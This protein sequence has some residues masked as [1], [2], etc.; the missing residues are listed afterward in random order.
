MNL[1]TYQLHADSD[2]AC[3]TYIAKPDSGAF[4]RLAEFGAFTDPLVM[5]SAHGCQ[6]AQSSLS[7]VRSLDWSYRSSRRALT[8]RYPVKRGSPRGR[9]DGRRYLE[10]PFFKVSAERRNELE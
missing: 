10:I 6:L 7:V 2:I 5:F 8:G 3:S 1:S 4:E 9:G